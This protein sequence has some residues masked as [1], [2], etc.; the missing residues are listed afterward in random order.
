MTGLTA[1]KAA[2]RVEAALRESTQGR[3]CKGLTTHH[4]V[5]QFADGRKPYA[6]GEFHHA[7]DAEFAERCHE[8]LPI[9]LAERRELLAR[10]E[11]FFKNGFVKGRDGEHSLISANSDG[12]VTVAADGYALVPRE[13]YE[14]L[15]ARQV[16]ETPTEAMIVAFSEAAVPG[17][18]VKTSEPQKAEVRAG[19]TKA[20]KAMLATAPPS[21]TATD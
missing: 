16:P 8:L 13:H 5:A 7:V 15:L 1:Q 4:T 9:L 14:E 6:I 17:A 10:P 3:W 18:W 12:S 20:W 21:L 11:S 2:E 19:V